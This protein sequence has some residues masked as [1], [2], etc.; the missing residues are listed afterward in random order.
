MEEGVGYNIFCIGAVLN[1]FNLE[2]YPRLEVG[3]TEEFYDPE[4]PDLG[5]LENIYQNLFYIKIVDALRGLFLKELDSKE[6]EM[7]RVSPLHIFIKEHSHWP[8][9]VTAL[10]Q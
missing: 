2:F 3:S 8:I 10:K 5:R 9:H 6:L 7:K 4:G 1:R